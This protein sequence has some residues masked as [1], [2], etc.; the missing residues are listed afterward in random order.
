M[1]ELIDDWKRYCQG[2]LEMDKSH[3]LGLFRSEMMDVELQSA[4]EF[5]PAAGELEERLNRVLSAGVLERHLYLQRPPV[6]DCQSPSNGCEGVASGARA[7]LGV[8]W[9][10]RAT[11]HRT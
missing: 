8:D 5:F 10:V 9:T 6:T 11:D 7:L 1:S 2:A 4:L 3:F